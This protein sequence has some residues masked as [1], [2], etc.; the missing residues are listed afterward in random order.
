MPTHINDKLEANTNIYDW[1]NNLKFLKKKYNL[2]IRPHPLSIT[3]DNKLLHNLKKTH[4]FVDKNFNRHLGEIIKISDIVLCDYGGSVFNAIFLEKPTILLNMK[5]SSKYVS[6]LIQNE[7]LDIKIRKK[8][9]NLN[10]NS[11]N[12]K[13]KKYVTKALNYNYKNKIKN[14]KNEFFEQNDKKKQKDINKFL[15][16]TISRRQ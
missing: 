12:S 6:E 7:S 14:L 8:L 10:I 11:D 2:I 5:K 1:I 9:I 13:I 15:L 4:F 16:K 3:Y